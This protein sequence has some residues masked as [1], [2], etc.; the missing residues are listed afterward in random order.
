[1]KEE[2]G[3][4]REKLFE[5]ISAL[6]QL[7]SEAHTVYLHCTAGVARSPT[8]AIGYLHYCMGWEL[9][10]AARYLKQVRK[11]SPYLEAL[12]LAIMDHAKRESCEWWTT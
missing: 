12:G 3:E 1:M 7:L 4:L 6:D 11:C 5:C 10:A 8:V 2:P 9:N